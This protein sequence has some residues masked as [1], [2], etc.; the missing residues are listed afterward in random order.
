MPA[1]C[2]KRGQRGSHFPQEAAKWAIQARHLRP[3]REPTIDQPPASRSRLDSALVPRRQAARTN[4]SR[5]RPHSVGVDQEI[6]CRDNKGNLTAQKGNADGLRRPGTESRRPGSRG[7][8]AQSGFECGQWNAIS[9]VA[10]NRGK[11]R[12]RPCVRGSDETGARVAGIVPAE[13]S[14]EEEGERWSCSTPIT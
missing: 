1:A 12:R 4:R 11:L 5:G 9:L 6:P 2:G 7:G 8:Q 3:V 14:S 10:G 13:T